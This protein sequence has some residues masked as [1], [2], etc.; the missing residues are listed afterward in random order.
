MRGIWE[1]IYLEMPLFLLVL[2]CWSVVNDWR[3]VEFGNLKTSEPTAYY[4]V[5]SRL[6]QEYIPL[7]QY[8]NYTIYRGNRSPAS[9]NRP[10]KSVHVSPPESP[11]D[12]LHLKIK[13]LTRASQ[14]KES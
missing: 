9:D 3:L 14:R 1:H 12:L 13:N 6:E 2:T 11:E 10:V 5:N 4:F 7:C 8:G